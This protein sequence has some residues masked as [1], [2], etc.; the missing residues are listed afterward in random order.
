MLHIVGISVQVGS[1]SSCQTIMANDEIFEIINPEPAP[2][3]E[4]TPEPEPPSN[5]MHHELALSKLR[6]N[7][8][9]KMKTNGRAKKEAQA[10]EWGFKTVAERFQHLVT[11]RLDARTLFNQG[12][13]LKCIRYAF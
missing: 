13:V 10:I 11:R 7:F 9:N 2:G 6:K 3:P 8:A 4:P 1:D 12:F 5:R